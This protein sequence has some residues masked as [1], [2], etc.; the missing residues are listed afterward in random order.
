MR[1]IMQRIEA[2]FLRAAAAYEVQPWNGRL[3][4]FR[5]PPRQTLESVW[6]ANGLN[7]DRD[8]VYHDNNWT[9]YAPALEVYEV[10][11]RKP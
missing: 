4:L 8:F 9:Q 6:R 3:V 5:P 11:G 2:A 1:S 10:P 7:H